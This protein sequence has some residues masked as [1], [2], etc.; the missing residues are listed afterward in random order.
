LPKAGT[1]LAE[2]VETPLPETRPPAPAVDEATLEGIRQRNAARGNP[3]A[4]AQLVRG[5]RRLI[6]GEQ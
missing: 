5:R 1:T 4:W 3:A 6:G 2:L